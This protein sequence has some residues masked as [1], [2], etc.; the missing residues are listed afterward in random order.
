MP[1]TVSVVRNE[2]K[3]IAAGISPNAQAAVASTADAI[4]EDAVAGAPFASIAET[5]S[6]ESEEG[7]EF[8]KTVVVGSWWGGFW[9]FGTRNFAARPYLTPATEQHRHA[10]IEQLRRVFR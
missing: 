8:K 10:L 7:D 4:A 3:R 2:F 1:V 6:V 5:I 9:E